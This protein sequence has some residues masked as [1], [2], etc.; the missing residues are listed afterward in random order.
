VADASTS[1]VMPDHL[2]APISGSVFDH[3]I[4]QFKY[5]PSHVV[6]DRLRRLD[7]FVVYD[8][9]ALVVDHAD[10]GKFFAVLC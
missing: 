1:S 8:Y 9:S 3:E 7:K 5:L 10:S 4:L 2:I 6:D